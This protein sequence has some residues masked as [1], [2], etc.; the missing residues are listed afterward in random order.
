MTD[1]INQKRFESIDGL[2][3]ISCLMIA[4]IWHYLIFF[5]DK[6]SISIYFCRFVELFVAISGFMIAH[7]YRTKI[8]KYSFS[9]FFGNRYFKIMPLYWITFVCSVF[10]LIINFRISANVLNINIHDINI[11]NL[12]LDFFGFSSA[13]RGDNTLFNL[14]GPVWTINV[15]LIC[16][17]LYFL[18]CRF[19]EKSYLKYILF[20][21]LILYVWLLGITE[22]WTLPFLTNDI[23]LRCYGSFAIGL[24]TYEIYDKVNS[25]FLMKIS[26]IGFILLLIIILYCQ[27]FDL[28]LDMIVGDVRVFTILFVCPILI[29]SSIYVRPI[30]KIL[31]SKLFIFLGKISFDVYMWHY[32][33]RNLLMVLGI[34]EVINYTFNGWILYIVLTMIVSILSYYFLE[35][36]INKIFSVFLT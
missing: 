2:K 32:I 3:G 13:F 4:F 28:P 12:L 23:T 7:N 27:F 16:Y 31:S 15:L 30:E 34:Q 22:M 10:I 26:W 14:N 33:V 8:Y 35:K 17:I 36:R 19:A 20:I 1:N 9:K 5:V 21:S 18:I 29:L 11:L 25:N 24:L 6:I